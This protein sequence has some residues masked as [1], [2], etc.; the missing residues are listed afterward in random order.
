MTSTVSGYCEKLRE[1]SVLSLI[2]TCLYSH[3]NTIRQFEDTEVKSRN[4]RASGQAFEVILKSPTD[5]SQERL[6][7]LKKQKK[8]KPSLKDLQR[9]LQAAEERRKCQE[10]KVLRH[11]A[12]KREREK[13]VLH[14]AQELNNNYSKMT[15]EKLN[16]KMEQI[17]ENRTAR[18][19]ALKQRLREKEIH[20]D[21][22]RRNKEL[23][24]ELSG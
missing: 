11:L 4:K 22:V 3:P 17:Q 5:L 15:E 7:V 23:Y 1:M 8:K 10:M 16:H 14:K 9:R 20:G 19:N 13:E 6:K 2:C 18:L 24:T 12:E 21:E